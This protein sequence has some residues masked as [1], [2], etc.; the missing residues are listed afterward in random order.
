MTR[1]DTILIAVVINAGLLAIL[2]ATA[3]IYDT[4]KMLEQPDF[5][6]SL[7]DGKDG[8]PIDVS[9]NLIAT[10]PAATVDEVD[11]VLKYYSQ[12]PQ[13]LKMES[14][15][16]QYIPEP[17]AVQ[18]N[19]PDDEDLTPEPAPIYVGK[20]VE[21]SVK[22]GD[23]LEKIAR[24]NG[25]TV[26]AIKKANQMQNERLSIG[27]VLK[28]PV[29]KEKTVVAAAQ[30]PIQAKK[31]AEAKTSESSSAE[32]VYYVIKSGDN[33]W[34]VAKQFN[35]KYDDILR[36]NQLDEEKARNLKIGDRIRVK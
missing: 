11:N 17:I 19:A 5:N 23:M 36:L 12:P 33:P 3:I 32:A 35:V 22:K 24:A 13:S 18:T 8:A 26:E 25:T 9:P 29:K 2:F 7:A 4:D 6:S 20:F 16:D 21:V 27:Q 1:K 31:Q 30:A 28:I 10:G 34:K 15:A 14:P